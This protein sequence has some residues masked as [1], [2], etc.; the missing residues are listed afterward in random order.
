MPML[1]ATRINDNEHLAG[2]GVAK[3]QSEAHQ[4]RVWRVWDGDE[5]GRIRPDNGPR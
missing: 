1:P 5:R 4:A 3:R 2:P